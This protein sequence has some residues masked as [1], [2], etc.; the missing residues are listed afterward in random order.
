MI[1]TTGPVSLLAV[2]NEFGKDATSIPINNYYAGKRIPSSYAGAMGPIPTSG[3][4]QFRQFRGLQL[5]KVS[6]G[7]PWESWVSSCRANDLS[8]LPS[9]MWFDSHIRTNRLT[10][11]ITYS[12]LSAATSLGTTWGSIPTKPTY[13]GLVLDDLSNS[14]LLLLISAEPVDITGT[15]PFV[16]SMSGTVISSSGDG[17]TWTAHNESPAKSCNL[18]VTS[19]AP[20]L[21]HRKFMGIYAGYLALSR[22]IY[23]TEGYKS[24]HRRLSIDGSNSVEFFFKTEGVTETGFH[25]SKIVTGNGVSLCMGS[26]LKYLAGAWTFDPNLNTP[27]AVTNTS[28][29]AYFRSTDTIN[30]IGQPIQNPVDMMS[31]KTHWLRELYSIAFSE[32]S[33][34]FY[35][36]FKFMP[37]GVTASEAE[38]YSSTDG[39]SWTLVSTLP[40]YSTSPTAS[41]TVQDVHIVGSRIIVCG[42]TT[43]TAPDL[44]YVAY[45]DDNAAT[46]TTIQIPD[47]TAITIDTIINTAVSVAS[48]KVILADNR[49]LYSTGTTLHSLYLE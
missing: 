34:K 44:A 14:G 42:Y 35:A 11:V 9:G 36:F 30:W 31:V 5:G 38:V 23:T 1:P 17:S 4:I 7:G 40:H 19:Y 12:Q 15:G 49:L 47:V 20:T 43:A 2:A 27:D 22:I 21:M 48:S 33:G 3:A 10:G 24:Q 41:I 29:G 6:T 46:W 8:L 18:T 13:N 26:R 28:K 25:P 16:Q 45:S 32:A 39:I 37:Y